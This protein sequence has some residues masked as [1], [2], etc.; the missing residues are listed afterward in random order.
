LFE[1]M[2]IG[3]EAPKRRRYYKRLPGQKDNHSY[4]EQDR[5]GTWPMQ[6][7]AVCRNVL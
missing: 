6:G 4:L 1:S 7:E 5:M 2:R 3:I